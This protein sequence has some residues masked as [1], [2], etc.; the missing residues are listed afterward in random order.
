MILLSSKYHRRTLRGSL[1]RIAI[2]PTAIAALQRFKKLQW[3]NP[4]VLKDRQQ[5]KLRQIITYASA[6]VPFYQGLFRE[7]RIDP[8]SIKTSE[9][10]TKLP[11]VTRKDLLK[12]F[13]KMFVPGLSGR[14]DLLTSS[15]SSGPAVSCYVDQVTIHESIATLLLFN[16]WASW[17]PGMTTLQIM[18]TRPERISQQVYW[19]L[20][21]TSF[22]N[23]LDI[24]NSTAK[25]FANL[26]A[27]ANPS[28]I[29]SYPSLLGMIARH[30]DSPPPSLRGVVV[31]SETVT[32]N[33][34]R[35]IER[36]FARRVF[37]RYGLSEFGGVLMQDCVLHQGLHLNSELAVVEVLDSNDE[38]VGESE[39]GRL[40]ITGL[41]NFVMPLIRYDVGDIGIVGG[42]CA[43]ARGFPVI[44]DIVGRTSDI[45]VAKNG[46][47]ISSFLLLNAIHYYEYFPE[48]IR[49][50]QFVEM[51]PGKL[52]LRIVPTKRFLENRTRNAA[53]IEQRLEHSLPILEFK[54]Q[55]RDEL[56]RARSGKQ[57]LV[58]R[59]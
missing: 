41:R 38:Q 52:G 2:L 30:T 54:V 47:E 21:R 6:N 42:E 16:L 18:R 3:I 19:R 57:N 26:I 22:L 48:F 43:C 9:D 50:F 25:S 53:Y 35:D 45:V 46:D 7:K 8:S 23:S 39:R 10:L 12:N 28:L 15:G 34:A 55:A 31:G 37:N 13:R 56:Q 24:R 17:L 40:V 14:G 29:I 1:P 32:P 58:V 33:V 4:S 44:S 11:I 59:E 36:G 20:M 5:Q 51:S 49:E 27:S